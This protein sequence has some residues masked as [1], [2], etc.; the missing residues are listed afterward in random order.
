MVKYYKN[1]ILTYD[2]YAMI[3]SMIYRKALLKN[4]ANYYFDTNDFTMNQ[5]GIVCGLYARDEEFT[6]TINFC[7]SRLSGRSIEAKICE[8]QELDHEA[9]K[10]LGLCYQG[11]MFVDRM[12]IHKDD[13]CEISLDCNAYLGCVDYELAIEYTVAGEKMAITI[14]DG[15]VRSMLPGRPATIIKAALNRIDNGKTKANR[16]FER[17]RLTMC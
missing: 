4:Q 13:T 8:R 7:N 3:S 14:L 9:F 11:E 15:I 17:K 1:V 5:N 2:E 12:L 6:T 10:V 16:F